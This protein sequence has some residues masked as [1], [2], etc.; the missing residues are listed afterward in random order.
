MLTEKVIKTYS[1]KSNTVVYQRL[2]H[3]V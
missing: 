3:M 2:A 1:T